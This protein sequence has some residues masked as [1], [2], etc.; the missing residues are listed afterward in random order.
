MANGSFGDFDQA[1]NIASCKLDSALGHS[2]GNPRCIE[3]LP[4]RGY[5]FIAEVSI[6]DFDDGTMCC[7]FCCLTQY[8]SHAGEKLVRTI[9]ERRMYK[10]IAFTEIPCN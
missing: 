6:G 8:L 3:A 1:V 4:R 7:S 2:A 9:L 10:G 5:R